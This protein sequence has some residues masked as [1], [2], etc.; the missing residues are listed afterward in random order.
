MKVRCISTN[1]NGGII[2]DLTL[3]KEYELIKED[4]EHYII[5]DDK[6]VKTGYFKDRFEV[7]KEKNMVKKEI[8]KGWELIRMCEEGKIE[9]G[10]TLQDLDGEYYTVFDGI[11]VDGE[12]EEFDSNY[13]TTSSFFVRNSFRI[14]KKKCTFREAYKFYE[15]GKEIESYDG[16]RF[17][18]IDDE[19][20][21][22][23]NGKWLNF[24]NGISFSIKQ[25]RNKW[26]IND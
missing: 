13:E 2:L 26:Y 11:V 21:T 3:N 25:I 16:S 18:K 10:T 1:N 19:D 4:K 5:L 17:K 20:H 22:W 24:N 9:N 12:K 6:N 14:I 7:V 15:E 23:F 8:F